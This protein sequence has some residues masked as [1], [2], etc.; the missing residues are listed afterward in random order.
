MIFHLGSG[1]LS[2]L[3]DNPFV[4]ERDLQQFFEEHMSTITGYSL[5]QT[6]FSVSGYRMDSVA[7]DQERSAF[8]IVEY[9]RGQNESLVDQG[10]AYLATIL[11]R[12]SDFV[13]LFNE[14]TGNSKRVADFD[15]SQTRIIFVSPKFTKYQKD[16]TTFGNIAFELI[17]VR[18]YAVNIIVVEHVNQDVNRTFQRTTVAGTPKQVADTNSIIAKVD[19]QVREYDLAY[20]Y[21]KSKAN[22]FVRTTYE[23]MRDRILQFDA[24]L[25]ESFTKHYISFKYAGRHNI[26]SFWLRPTSIE[27]VLV[28]KRGDIVDPYGITYDISNRLWSSE[29]YAFKLQP[30]S[31]LDDAMDLIR[32]AYKANRRTEQ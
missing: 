12:R 6:E 30:T 23:D 24:S 1:V 22:E 3:Q 11:D 9:K 19:S 15:W 10:Y 13:L 16:A 5:L 27:V 2:E 31:S 14:K 18:R 4:L 32:R 7:F 17:E 28:A 25:V 8:V 29:Q 20:H 26:V 21:T